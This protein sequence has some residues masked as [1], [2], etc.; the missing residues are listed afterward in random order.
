M[1]CEIRAIISTFTCCAVA[2]AEVGAFTSRKIAEWMPNGEI[3]FSSFYVWT[4]RV[5]DPRF[6]GMRCEVMSQPARSGSML[7]VGN[8]GNNDAQTFKF[9]L[10]IHPCS[11][12]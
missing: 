7:E 9:I 6:Q 8:C 10:M 1:Q 3:F 5:P 2:C 12:A 4:L 11:V